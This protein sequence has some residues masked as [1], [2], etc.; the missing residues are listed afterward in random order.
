MVRYDPIK[1]RQQAVAADRLGCAYAWRILPA[2]ALVIGASL[3]RV[4]DGGMTALERFIR[5]GERK[6]DEGHIFA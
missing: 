1:M 2:I 3:A 5:N 6:S 4:G